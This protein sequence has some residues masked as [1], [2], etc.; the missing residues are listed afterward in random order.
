MDRLVI[1]PAGYTTETGACAKHSWR[2]VYPCM[3]RA[4]STKTSVGRDAKARTRPFGTITELVG[5]K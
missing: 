5:K 2:G 4:Q 3:H 1:N